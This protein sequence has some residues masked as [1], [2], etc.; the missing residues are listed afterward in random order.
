MENAYALGDLVSG[1][2]KFAD[3]AKGIF[4]ALSPFKDALVLKC[5]MSDDYVDDV[6]SEFP[7]ASLVK[8]RVVFAESGRVRLS[9]RRSIVEGDP[10]GF[11]SFRKGAAVWAVI[12]EV[13]AFGVFARLCESRSVGLCHVSK[14][15]G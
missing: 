3:P 14:V 6:R 10:R 11:R 12:T 13:R 4:V 5:D 7:A 1:Y 8:G 9:L 2:V 15:F